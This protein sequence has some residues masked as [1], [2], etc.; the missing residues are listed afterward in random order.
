M[1][2]ANSLRLLVATLLGCVCLG[3]GPAPAASLEV[4]PREVELSTA[5]DRQ[6][7]VVQLVGDDGVTRDVSAEA[8]VAPASDAVAAWEGGALAPRGDGATVAR[9]SFEGLEAEVAVRVAD[10]GQTPP[11]S[12]RR[13]VQPILMKAG[14]NAGR[15]H[16]AAR[17]KDGFQ[18]SLFGFDPVGDHRR[19]TTELPGRRVNAARPEAS[20]LVTKAVG[21]APHSGGKR[22]AEDHPWRDDVVRWIEEGAADDPGAPEVVRLEVFP[23]AAVLPA[24]GSGGADPTQ[25]LVV[26]AVYADGTDRDVTDLA[27]YLSNN[28]GTAKVSPTGEVRGGA[29]GE[30]FVMARYATHTEGMRVVVAPAE[31]VDD[32]AWPEPAGEVDRLIHAKLRRLRVSPA[33]PCD[34]ERFLRRVSIDLTGLTPTA[35]RHAAFV[36]DSRPDKRERLVEELLATDDFVDLWAMRFGELLKIRTSN[37]V[38]YKAL[39]GFHNWVR[40]RVARGEPL[41]RMLAEVLTATGGTFDSPPTNFFQIEANTQLLAENVAQSYLGARVQCA[42]CHNHPFDRWTTD[43]YYG[44]AAFFSQVGFKQS[45]DPREFVVYNRGEGE[46]KSIVDGRAVPPK[47]LGAPATPVGDRDRRAALA[48]WIVSDEN[49]AFS[50]NLANVVWAHHFGRGIVEPVDDVRISNPPT[51]PELLDY[52]AGRLR[53][54]GYDLRAL[55]REIVLSSAYQASTACEEQDAAAQVVAAANFAHAQVRRMRAEALLD[56]VSLV[57]GSVDRFPRLPIGARSIEIADGAVSNYF[58]TTFGRAPRDT[59]CACEVDS[60]PTLSQA[61]HLLNG[62]AT[63][64]KVVDGALV[65]RL[66]DAGQTPAE[67]IERLHVLCYAR[68]PRDEEAARLLASVDPGAP[69]ESLEDV[70]WAL[71]NSKEFLFNH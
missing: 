5:R 22:F 69:A 24:G 9:V 13:D 61:F 64:A 33:P 46:A 43:D 32:T 52:L 47:P 48:E 23:P 29:R 8:A 53:E 42:Q 55:V 49:P 11:V 3:A 35:E 51:N 54:S 25:R 71:L 56:S 65:P 19:L 16:G 28:D 20:L 1:T 36:A 27:V 12:L 62:E 6:R 38:S 67:V 60:Q 40:D 2:P 66:L 70:F 68:R 41:D 39:L 37:Q 10:A 59:V 31:P 4:F 63:N 44:F 45:A 18:L 7:L 26:R 58:L 57:T 34:D 50:R 15:C 14:C 17:G 30:A 21:L